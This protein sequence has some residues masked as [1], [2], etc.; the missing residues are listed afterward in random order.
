MG[1]LIAQTW[2]GWL[3]VAVVFGILEVTVPLFGFIFAS[4]AALVTAIV[5]VW[6]PAWEIQAVVFGATTLIG[7]YFLRPKLLD[8]SKSKGV[9]SRTD[10]LINKTARVVEAIDPYEGKGRVIVDGHD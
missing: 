2:I 1:L 6:F 9:P 5:A 10:E 8:P 4:A 3:V 7:L